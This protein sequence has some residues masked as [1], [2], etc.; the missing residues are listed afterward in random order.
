MEE[1]KNRLSFFYVEAIKAAKKEILQ[2][3]K[4]YG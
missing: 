2:K 1:E 4:N 3:L